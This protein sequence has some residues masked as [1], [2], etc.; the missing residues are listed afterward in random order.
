MEYPISALE[1]ILGCQGG[2]STDLDNVGVVQHFNQPNFSEQHVLLFLIPPKADGRKW[3]RKPWYS[4]VRKW[5][6]GH[7]LAPPSTPLLLC[8]AVCRWQRPLYLLSERN[9]FQ[10]K[11]LSCRP[12]LHL[13]HA[14]RATLLQLWLGKSRTAVS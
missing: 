11:L 4:G 8:C 5:R 6:G 12:L 10:C 7:H 13:V 1:Q 9:H 14:C 2:I 3:R